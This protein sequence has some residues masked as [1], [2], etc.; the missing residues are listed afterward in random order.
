VFAELCDAIDIHPGIFK[1]LRPVFFEVRHY[2][3][4]DARNLGVTFETGRESRQPGRQKIHI[5]VE[6][7]DDIPARFADPPVLRMRVP[8]NWL[9]YVSDPG[10][11]CSESLPDLS[12]LIGGIVIQQKQLVIDAIGPAFEKTAHRLFE[13]AIPVVRADDDADHS[14]SFFTIFMR[15]IRCFTANPFPTNA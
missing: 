8:L 6:K 11:S 15:S 13:H 4:P 10:K 2:P 5:I 12:R 3:A 9:I 1:P 7:G 14:S